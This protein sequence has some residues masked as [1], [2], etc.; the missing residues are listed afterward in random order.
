MLLSSLLI[1]VFYAGALASAMP[2]VK[3][4]RH[5]VGPQWVFWQHLIYA[6]IV[7]DRYMS[8]SIVLNAWLISRQE[9]SERLRMVY[10]GRGSLTLGSLNV[11]SRHT[12]STSRS[13]PC[14][15]TK[16]ERVVSSRKS[17]FP[18]QGVQSFHTPLSDADIKAQIKTLND[19]FNGTGISWVLV[20]MTRINSP[21]WFVHAFPGR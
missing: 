21:N 5:E 9:T 20:K 16:L 6:R 18:P 2:L 7:F 19:D 11:K 12:C 4:W 15:P 3:N 14:T 13:M 1:L 17:L 10:L 8:T